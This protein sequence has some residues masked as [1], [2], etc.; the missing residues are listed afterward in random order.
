MFNIRLLS[1]VMLLVFACV[2][3]GLLRLDIDADVVRSLPAGERVIGDGLEIF[4][5]HPIHDQVAIDIMI[6]RNDPDM[7]VECGAFFEEQLR[8]SGLFTV[9]GTKEI[10]N[11]IPDLALHVAGNLPLLY[12]AADLERYVVPLLHN[13]TVPRRLRQTA[14]NLGS[15]E[16]IGQASFIEKDPLGLRD[17][18]MARLALLAPSTKSRVYRDSL[19][20]LDGRHL[21]VTAKPVTAGTNTAAARKISQLIESG[22]ESLSRK[23]ADQGLQVTVTPVGAYRAAMDNERIIRHDVQQAL[24][25]ATGGIALL[26]LFSFHRP[27]IG[28]LSLLPAVAGTAA[29]LLVYSLFHS[30]ISIMVLGFG[31]AIISI[32][33]DQG[34]AYLLFLDCPQETRGRDAAREVR[35]VGILAVLTTIGSF[36][37]LS[38]SGFPIFTQL[39]QFTALGIFFSFL[40][41]HTVFPRI[42]PTMPPAVPRTLPLRKLVNVLYSTGK[43]GAAVAVLLALG[44]LFFARPEF[45]VSLSSMNTVSKETM[46][47]DDLFSEVWGDIGDRVYLMTSADSMRELQQKNDRLLEKINLD[48]DSERLGPSFVPSMIFPGKE[49]AEQNLAAWRKFWDQARR[50]EITRELNSAGAALGFTPEAFSPFLS[51]LNPSLQPAAALVLPAPYRDLLGIADNDTTGQLIQF[52]TITPG[53]YYDGSDFFARYSRDGRIFDSLFFSERLADILFSTFTTMLL[54]IAVSIALFLLLFFSSWQLTILTLIPVIF[55]YICTLGTLNLIGHPL[56]IPSLML[57]IVILGMGID[58]SIF[59]VR[60]HQRYGD[61]DHPAYALVRTAVFMAGISTLIGFGVLC[62]ADHSLLRS[63]G[64][65][66][67]FGI[68]YS[69]LGTFLLLPPLLHMYFSGTDRYNGVDEDIALRVRRRFRLL[70]TYPRMFA[71][72]KLLFDPMFDDL[73]RMLAERKE[74]RVLLDIGCGYGVPA[75][76]CLEYIPEARVFGIDPDPEKVR[77]ASRATGQRGDIIQGG[78]PDLPVVSEPVDVILM[79]DMLHYL[80]DEAVCSV[81]ERGLRLLAPAGILVIRFVLPPAGKPSWSWRFED[82]RLKKNSLQPR[83]RSADSM[84]EMLC[85]AGFVPVISEVSITNPELMW[86][87]VRA[88]GK[89]GDE[90]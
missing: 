58:Y 65:T 34:I 80:N 18:L 25:L 20:S 44:L 17:P 8:N 15:L 9:V 50:E 29:A 38:F 85:R 52:I 23:Y 55:A 70:E 82:Y 66:S 73:P 11:L 63:I 45:H 31:G 33:V 46:A 16:S 4:R 71:R 30:S 54:I 35:A 13:D 68:A 49:R 2:G 57:S 78:A 47:A 77:V 64:I 19:I 14:D 7:L 61:V 88:E 72:F 51:M 12:S 89:S 26:L 37:V 59:T 42:F 5:N 81:L 53:K 60:A 76:W 27:L 90:Q 22:S 28:L 62:L 21:L 56:D 39:G 36:M 86:M 84:A 69:L 3:L 24:L 67:F 40:F 79:L 10:G 41:V 87:V 75:C 74:V 83:Y 48:I 32:T 43:T 1:I 6:N